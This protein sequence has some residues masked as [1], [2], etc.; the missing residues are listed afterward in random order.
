MYY[1][2]MGF[3]STGPFVL[4]IYRI[5][6]KDV[7]YFL[8]FYIV[9]LAALASA[10]S[11]LTN[12]G[13]PA[14]G[15]GL[16][17]FI[18]TLWTLLKLTVN[19][20][21]DYNV[22]GIT[23]VPND[24]QWFYDIIYTAFTAVAVLLLVNILIAIIGDTYQVYSDVAYDIL[25]MEKYNIMAAQELCSSSQ[26]NEMNRGKYSIR[27]PIVKIYADATSAFDSTS[28]SNKGNE[29]AAVTGK[30]AIYEQISA[31][32]PK[33]DLWYFKL[34]EVD[35]EWWNRDG[36]STENNCDDKSNIAKTVL[37]ILD[38]Q[39]SFHPAKEA[40]DNVG[41]L[42]YR[43]PEGALAVKGA[44]EDSARVAKMILENMEQIDEIFVSMDT[45][46]RYDIG[47]GIFWRKA[48]GTIPEP[49]FTF[50]RED[51]ERNVIKPA[52]S[53]DD[54]KD[55]RLR[56]RCI[57]YAMNLHAKG[58]SQLIIWPEHCLIGSRGHQVVSEIND[59]LQAWTRAKGKIVNY[60]IKGV[61]PYTEMYSALK[62]EVEDPTDKST[63]LNS[64]L[65]GQLRIADRI[66]ICGEALSHTVNYTCRD[67]CQYIDTNRVYLLIDG[68]SP[69]PGFESQAKEFVQWAVNEGV[70][71]V[72]I[73]DVF[74]ESPDVS[75]ADPNRI[76]LM[77]Q[78]Q[79]SRQLMK[80][81]LSSRNINDDCDDA[82]NSSGGVLQKFGIEA[83]I[84][85][86]SILVEAAFSIL[87]I[88]DNLLT[89]AGVESELERLGVVAA[90]DLLH[91]KEVDIRKISSYLKRAQTSKF[92]ACFGF[93]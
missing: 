81:I 76:G 26:T 35:E 7:P 28:K 19:G 5:I 37:F 27:T 16:Y 31:D 83:Q 23:N 39:N 79:S 38:P 61:N 30:A 46:N 68:T 87:H 17:R 57:T 51:I 86:R 36:G 8:Q 64:E 3:D 75:T 11:M 47:H 9:I 54:G 40:F 74:D 80:S 6:S 20:S 14:E 4:K 45:H 24:L 60:I 93:S 84:I 41:K 10:L 58:I 43:R 13:N 34:E 89:H 15:A 18:L 32:E 88:P 1:F 65:I 2:L 50:N 56:R 55:D 44:N 59:A 69:V 53:E 63:A 62:A 33:I 67:L 77:L 90:D 25:L 52:N 70:N 22:L 49:F 78:Q 71:V 82:E 12:D 91:L 85:A 66:L 92:L 29:V 48:D 73:A 42:L 72:K 21:D